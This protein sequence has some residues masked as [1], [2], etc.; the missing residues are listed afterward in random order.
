MSLKYFVKDVC[1]ADY[2]ITVILQIFG[3]LKFRWRAISE[4]SVSVDAVVVVQCNFR[5]LVSF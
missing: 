5:I 1:I 4:Q 3:E 2:F